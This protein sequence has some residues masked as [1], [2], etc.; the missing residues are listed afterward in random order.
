MRESS[1]FEHIDGAKGRKEGAI[2][3]LLGT[4]HVNSLTSKLNNVECKDGVKR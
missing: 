1:D 2:A 4:I 3:V